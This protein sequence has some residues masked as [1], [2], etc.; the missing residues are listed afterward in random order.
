MHVPSKHLDRCSMLTGLMSGVLELAVAKNPPRRT[1][2]LDLDKAEDNLL[3]FIKI[4]ASLDSKNTVF[5]WLGHKVDRGFD[6]L[7]VHLREFVDA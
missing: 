4:R 5:W 2:K 7:P 1:H 3:A 6:G